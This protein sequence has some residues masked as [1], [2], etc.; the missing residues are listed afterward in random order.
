MRC[1]GMQDEAMSQPRAACTTCSQVGPL[2]TTQHSLS[3]LYR[4]TPRSNLICDPGQFLGTL[5]T[6]LSTKP[7]P[8]TLYCHE[9]HLSPSADPEQ[10]YQHSGRGSLHQLNASTPVYP[11]YGGIG[12]GLG[13]STFSTSRCDSCGPPPPAFLRRTRTTSKSSKCLPRDPIDS[14]SFSPL[15]DFS[16][17]LS[18]SLCHDPHLMILR[19]RVIILTTPFV[20][21]ASLMCLTILRPFTIISFHLLTSKINLKFSNGA[22]Q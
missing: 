10:R 18:L 12:I 21:L 8:N 7:A 1:G 11:V 2:A 4:S 20:L 16:L 6:H 19:Y 22:I 17:S 14:I 13:S 15:S 5:T 9:T 3:L